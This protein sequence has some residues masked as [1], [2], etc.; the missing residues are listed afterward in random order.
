MATEKALR[1][2]RQR[3]PIP[4]NVP[5]KKCPG[6]LCQG[7]ERPL[8]EFYFRKS[9]R[10]VG[11]P[12]SYCKECGNFTARER[13]RKWNERNPNYYRQY[14][15]EKRILKPANQD[16][17]HYGYVPYSKVEFA[18]EEI[19]RILGPT[20]A[21]QRIGIRRSCLLMWR[22]RDV[23]KIYKERAARVFRALLEVR[24]ER[25]NLRKT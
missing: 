5:A 16:W 3:P 17:Q 8:T 19:C 12:L 7:Q 18:V 21:A 23:R 6:P 10:D 13:R 20:K 25:R 15:Q 22:R 14:D 2:K 11:K 4:A 9:G 24:N 1:V